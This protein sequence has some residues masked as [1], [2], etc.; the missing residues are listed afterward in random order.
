M[1]WYDDLWGAITD[2]GSTAVDWAKAN[3]EL[4]GAAA[5]ATIGAATGSDNILRDA[6]IGAGLGYGYRNYSQLAPTIGSSDAGSAATPQFNAAAGAQS[7]PGGNT[8]APAAGAG[9]DFG[10]YFGGDYKGDGFSGVGSS[11]PGVTSGLQ[12]TMDKLKGGLNTVRDFTKQNQDVM[13]LGAKGLSAL[14]GMQDDAA[15]EAYMKKYRQQA[16]DTAAANTARINSQN[17]AAED[18]YLDSRANVAQAGLRAEK[19]IQSQVA[20]QMAGLDTSSGLDSAAKAA[21][22]QKAQVAGAK[23]GS[24]AF[25]V[26][27]TNARA[28]IRA[29]QYATQNAPSYDS[30]Y[31]RDIGDASKNTTAGL[32]GLYDDVT[33]TSK[34]KAQDQVG[35][36]TG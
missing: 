26:A 1:A 30:T 12:G 20:Q 15:R 16:D 35:T 31:A 5:G 33:G 34:R 24:Q 23:A 17:K 2:F 11:A 7:L 4:A 27:D 22:K 14:Q 36:A 32:M 9:I 13:S 3:P 25:S 29:P 10:G 8:V 18:V 19:G 6:G 28:G 21:L